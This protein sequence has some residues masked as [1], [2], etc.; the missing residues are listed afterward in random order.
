MSVI[1]NTTVISNFASIGQ[2]DLLKQLYGTV[3]ISVEIYKEIQL[4]LAEGYQFY[5][6]VEQIIHP[7]ASEGWIRLTS[8]VSGMNW[9]YLCGFL[10]IC[11]QE[12]PLA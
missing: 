11:I 6:E 12:K 8:M 9:L 10:H 1:T 3:H 4:G 7:Y 2:P 5:R